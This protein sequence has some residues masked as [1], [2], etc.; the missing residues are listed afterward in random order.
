[1]PLSIPW[2]ISKQN[3]H[4]INTCWVNKSGAVKVLFSQWDSTFEERA[5]PIKLWQNYEKYRNHVAQEMLKD[6]KISYFH[7]EK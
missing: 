6:Y 1:M 2:I 4:Q 7:L 3:R 5:L